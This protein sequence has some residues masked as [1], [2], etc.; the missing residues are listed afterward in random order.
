M[1]PSSHTLLPAWK[2]PSLK[3]QRRNFGSAR[4]S[5]F[6]DAERRTNKSCRRITLQI[7]SGDVEIY[8]ICE[9]PFWRETVIEPSRT[10]KPAP[11][12]LAIPLRTSENWRPSAPVKRACSC[13]INAR[14][15]KLVPA[16][17]HEMRRGIDAA[18]GA[19]GRLHRNAHRE[20]H[21]MLRSAPNQASLASRWRRKRITKSFQIG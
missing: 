10:N 16:H 12:P 15:R 14:Y 3:R 13:Q 6:F 19:T 1:P 9:I 2:I 5:R 4:S 17:A 21:S 11:R 8:R 18:E 7:V 20:D